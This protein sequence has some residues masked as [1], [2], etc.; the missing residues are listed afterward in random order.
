MAGSGEPLPFLDTIQ[1]AF[2]SHDLGQVRAHTGSEAALA[3]GDLGAR[4]YATGTQIAFG[5]PP[6]LHTAAHEAAHVVQQRAGVQLKDNVGRAGDEYE[7]HADAVADLVVQGSS[8]E[9]LL[10][11]MAGPGGAVPTIH[12]VQ[13]LDKTPEQQPE[14][15]ECWSADMT[16]WREDQARLTQSAKTLADKQRLVRRFHVAMVESYQLP[17][18]ETGERRVVARRAFVGFY[19]EYRDLFVGMPNGD[20]ERAFAVLDRLEYLGK[21]GSIFG[22]WLKSQH[23]ALRDEVRQLERREVDGGATPP[24]HGVVGKTFPEGSGWAAAPDWDGA[25]MISAHS[26]SEGMAIDERYADKGVEQL[27]ALV[28]RHPQYASAKVVVLMGCHA[29]AMAPA[30]ARLLRRAVIGPEGFVYIADNKP[31]GHVGEHYTHDSDPVLAHLAE[32]EGDNSRWI[33]AREDGSSET[34]K[35][36][37]YAKKMASLGCT[38]VCK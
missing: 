34:F 30:L 5:E 4:A 29:G 36:P 2:G 35:T 23:D 16:R 15:K 1:A 33:L 20:F 31:P 19:Q 10:D 38:Q 8:A 21:A 24:Y 28:R 37:D 9:A 27:A 32:T 13:R 11:S 7:R 25:V 3:A 26:S 12:A 17:G 22:D 18:D 6:D 14:D